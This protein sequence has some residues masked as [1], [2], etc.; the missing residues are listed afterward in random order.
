VLHRFLTAAGFALADASTAAEAIERVRES[1]YELVL[2]DLALPDADAFQ[3]C[4]GIRELSPH[5]GIIGVRE[6]GTPDDD[7]RALDAGADDCVAAPFRFREVVARLGAVLRRTHQSTPV[8]R[9]NAVLRA[10]SLE[11]DVERRLFWRGGKPIHLSPKE[12]DL[13]LVFMK[14]QGV[15]LTHLKLLRA[16]WGAES[17]RDPVYLR[18]YVKALRKKIE[19][20][21]A[22]PEYLQTEPWVGYLFRN[23]LGNGS[24]PSAAEDE[25][26]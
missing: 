10:G 15:V 7:V 23:P 26:L 25:L 12:F 3:A 24:H 17:G 14:N 21:P 22:H 13:L 20:D 4:R 8:K 1:R 6:G 18:S 16:V 11:M 9:T 19:D 2:V 5:I